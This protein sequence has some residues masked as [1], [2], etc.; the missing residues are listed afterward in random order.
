MIGQGGFGIIYLGWD[1]N[2]DMKLAIKEY[3][4][5]G[6]VIRDCHTSTTLTPYTGEYEVFFRK[7]LEKFVDEAETVGQILLAAWHCFG[8]GLFSGEWNRLYCDGVY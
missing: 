4:P 8:S 5:N 2:L 7:G 6:F 3:Y 1:L